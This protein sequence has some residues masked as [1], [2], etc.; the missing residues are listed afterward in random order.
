[1]TQDFAAE[2]TQPGPLASSLEDGIQKFERVP[3]S[4]NASV[5][6]CS[7]RAI[8]SSSSFRVP[9]VIDEAIACAEVTCI[10]Y[11]IAVEPQACAKVS[12]TAANVRGPWPA[13]PCAV[14]MH[15]PHQPRLLHRGNALDR[16]TRQLIHLGGVPGADLMGDALG[17]LDQRPPLSSTP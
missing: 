5:V 10:T 6:R 14:G 2:V 4:E 12:T 9:K 1:V 15:S 16:E 13:P 7:P 3:F 17:S 8:V 11:T